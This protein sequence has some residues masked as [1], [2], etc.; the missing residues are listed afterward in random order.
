MGIKRAQTKDAKE[1]SSLSEQPGTANECC[2]PIA[3]ATQA[4][5]S[6]AAE[7]V[8]LQLT[9]PL[10]TSKKRA[11]STSSTDSSSSSTDSSSSATP[12]AEAISEAAPQA[13]GQPLLRAEEEVEP[14]WLVP[15]EDDGQQEVWLVTFAKV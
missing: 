4:N 7:H 9:S 1:L 11:R 2:L 14:D 5:T 8:D 12:D 10:P 6:A 15:E 3:L 13:E